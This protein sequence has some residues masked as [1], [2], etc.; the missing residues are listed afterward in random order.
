MVNLFFAKISYHSFIVYS[1]EEFKD[2]FDH[3][4]IDVSPET[5]DNSNNSIS[6]EAFDSLIPMIID[7]ISNFMQNNDISITAIYKRFKELNF[8]FMRFHE[9]LAY[10]AD[11]LLLF[12]SHPESPRRTKYS[13]SIL[14]CLCANPNIAQTINYENLE[15]A[16]NKVFESNGDYR[17]I[18]D[19]MEQFVKINLHSDIFFVIGFERYL[20]IYNRRP[21]DDKMAPYCFVG[22]YYISIDDRSPEF[23]TMFLNIVSET[24]PTNPLV[25]KCI[26]SIFINFI[27]SISFV[28]ELFLDYFQNCAPG[29]NV[30]VNIFDNNVGAKFAYIPKVCIALLIRNISFRNFLPYS[31]YHDLVFVHKD[32]SEMV[33][34]N[35]ASII[36]FIFRCENLNPEICYKYLDLVQEYFPVADIYAKSQLSIILF[37]ILNH[38]AAHDVSI[39]CF[40]TCTELICSGIQTQTISY[41]T[42]C[43]Y[44]N[45]IFDILEL[46]NKEEFIVSLVTSELCD[47]LIDE[48]TSLEEKD[49]RNSIRIFIKKYDDISNKYDL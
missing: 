32:T 35:L 28:E 11:M 14:K 25:I 31:F 40:N 21:Y 17:L 42:I 18:T 33:V 29:K 48:V 20:E 27:T 38:L 6:D 30:L 12:I 49:L 2:E 46:S 47:D 5:I 23:Q 16:I 3:L 37:L 9:S 7:G 36:T 1:M 13:L 34:E 43:Y 4:K 22:L 24:I 41:E 39:E 19:L 15:L 26:C 45:K 10:F 8:P 44:V